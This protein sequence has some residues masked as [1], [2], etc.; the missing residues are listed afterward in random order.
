MIDILGH[1]I[2]A[3]MTVLTNKYFTATM[4]E[5][6]TVDRVT[7]KAVIVTVNATWGYW[8]KENK[9]YIRMNGRKTIR[10]R[11]DQILVIDKQLNFNRSQ[12]PEN[13]L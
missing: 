6:T 5:I 8:D 11:P 13:M 9:K 1:P 3:G 4:G 7:P 2:E 12:Y 10:K